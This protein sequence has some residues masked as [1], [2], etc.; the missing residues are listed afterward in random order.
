MTRRHTSGIP[1]KCHGIVCI[2]RV[3][4][5]AWVIYTIEVHMPTSERLFLLSQ[6]QVKHFKHVFIE[7]RSLNVSQC[8]FNLLF[9]NDSIVGDLTNR[10]RFWDQKMSVSFLWCCKV[11]VFLVTAFLATRVRGPRFSAILN[12]L[13]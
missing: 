2:L 11:L 5:Q 4:M 10:S 3:S 13:V 8:N 7:F 12:H 6:L 1:A 9:G